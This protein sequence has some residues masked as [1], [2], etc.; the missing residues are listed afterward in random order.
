MGLQEKLENTRVVIRS[1][2]SKD[3]QCNGQ[4]KKDKRANNDLQNI[5][6][7]IKVWQYEPTNNQGWTQILQKGY[8]FLIH[9]ISDFRKPPL[10]RMW[11]MYFIRHTGNVVSNSSPDGRE[12]NLHPMC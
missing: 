3:R 9:I 8:H 12:S 10:Y 11:L 2:K 4:M 1:R 6:Q 5:S 7:Q